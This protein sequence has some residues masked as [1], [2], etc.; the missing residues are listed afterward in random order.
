MAFGNEPKDYAKSAGRSGFYACNAPP[1]SGIN[2]TDE[3]T[4]DE[5]R[6]EHNNLKIKP[7]EDLVG[8]I[9][10]VEPIGHA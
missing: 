3:K 9:D 2:V 6:I 7:S 10:D 8:L 5:P 4:I 1:Y